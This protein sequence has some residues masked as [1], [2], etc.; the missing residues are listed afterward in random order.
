MSLIDFILKAKRSGYAGGSEG[1]E[2]KFDDGSVGFEIIAD[3]YRYL[4]RY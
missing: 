3:G 4:D 1:N 2:R